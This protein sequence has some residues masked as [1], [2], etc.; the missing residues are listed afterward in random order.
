MAVTE[1]ELGLARASDGAALMQVQRRKWE[2]QCALHA[3]RL[4]HAG[5]Q[6]ARLTASKGKAGVGRSFCIEPRGSPRQRPPAPPALRSV[7]QTRPPPWAHTATASAPTTCGSSPHPT[8]PNLT[9]PRRRPAALPPSVPPM[10]ARGPGRQ[11]L[12]P[13]RGGRAQRGRAAHCAGQGRR[14]LGL[15]GVSVM[16]R[17][18]LCCA[19]PRCCAVLRG[20]AL[21]RAAAGACLLHLSP[22]GRLYGSEFPAGRRG[23]GAGSTK[24]GP[25]PWVCIAP[26]PLR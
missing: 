17:A 13:G 19:M 24:E 22:T 16:R 10:E 18:V 9:W 3:L 5:S 15:L 11:Q 14:G 6:A 12:G 7:F 21:C 2:M 23:A 8:S 25:S 4:R 1:G 20:A 26:V